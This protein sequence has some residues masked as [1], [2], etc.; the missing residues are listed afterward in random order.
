VSIGAVPGGMPRGI[1]GPHP[2]RYWGKYRA[3]VLDNIDPLAQARLLCDAPA[4]PGM[5]LNWALPCV[6]YAGM[7]EGFFA[8]P[9]IGAN[10][11]LEFENGDPSY[12][13]WTGCFWEIG[14]I[15][16]VYELSPE[17]PSLVKVFRSKYCTLVFNDTPEEGGMSLSAI[18][19]A[20]DVPVSMTMNSTGVEINV[21]PMTVLMNPEVGITI[22]AGETVVELTEE[23]ITA[24]APTI[25]VTAEED[26]SVTATTT[27]LE[28]EVN[29]IGPTDIEGPTSV[30]GPVGIEGA[31]DITG[32]VEISPELNVTGAVSVEGETNIAGALTVELET[33]IAGA[34][35]VELETNIAGALT[36]EGDVAVLGLIEGVVVPPI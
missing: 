15:P 24:E 25:E 33:N 1:P 21:G 36:V 16:L 4:L 28:S 18:D 35:T 2:A 26:V 34:L 10:V 3:T 22:S 11:W 17:D 14:E 31:V 12:P 5:L 27:T 29:V 7:E 19:P 13:I 6:P 8:L 20:V 30:S 23:N 32:V 9:P